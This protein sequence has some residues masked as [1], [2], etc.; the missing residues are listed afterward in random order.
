MEF[1][2]DP[3]KEAEN[4]RKHGVSFHEAQSVFGDPL[5]LT[6]PDTEHSEGESRLLILGASG[7]HRLVVACHTERSGRIRIIG[8][9]EATRRER[10]DYESGM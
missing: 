8:A 3:E 4:F 7:E 9:R 2:W 5:S 1:E 6:I 10:T